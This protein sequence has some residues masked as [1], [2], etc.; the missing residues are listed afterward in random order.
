VVPTRTRLEGTAVNLL[1]VGEGT[2]F[3]TTMPLPAYLPVV[4]LL[5]FRL[6][7]GPLDEALGVEE[8]RSA[9]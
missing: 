9:A 1:F 7:G 6:V 8:E 4:Y 3:P 2:C 5:I